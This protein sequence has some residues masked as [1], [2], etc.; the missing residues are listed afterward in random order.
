MT[1]YSNDTKQNKTKMTT[2]TFLPFDHEMTYSAAVHL[3]MAKALFPSS[4]QERLYS[5][6]A[7][8]ILDE[9]IIWGNRIA[10]ARKQELTRIEGLFQKLAERV[11][12]EGLRLLSL[13]GDTFSQH[14]S[15]N[16]TQQIEMG[17]TSVVDTGTGVTMQSSFQDT[18]SNPT[19]PSGT[20][21]LDFLESIGISSFEFHS[22]I[23]QINNPFAEEG[24]G[25]LDIRSDWTPGETY[26]FE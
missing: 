2:E 12:Q 25:N 23:N 20:A 7:H 8:A 6:N 22:I 1:L 4:T 24:S 13:S 9:L 19:D 15:F 11:E 17:R 21:G 16:V 18:Q 5:Q 26:S 3:T 10:T 14:D